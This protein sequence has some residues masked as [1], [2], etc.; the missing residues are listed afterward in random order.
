MIFSISTTFFFLE[1]KRNEKLDITDTLSPRGMPGCDLSLFLFQRD[2]EAGRE[3]LPPFAP[4]PC[5][6]W[7]KGEKPRALLSLP[8]QEQPL[9]AAYP[10]FSSRKKSQI[11][12]N[13]QLEEQLALSPTGGAG[14]GAGRRGEAGED[15]SFAGSSPKYQEF[16]AASLTY[17]GWIPRGAVGKVLS[18]F[19]AV[20]CIFGSQKSGIS[21]WLQA[22]QDR[23]KKKAPGSRESVEVSCGSPC[24]GTSP[25]GRS[26][27]DTK[28]W[29]SRGN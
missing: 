27:R 17:Q 3:K 5:G 21:H 6:R 12:Q 19:I 16:P 4:S 22:K 13:S 10:R 28:P 14:N 23:G 20:R 9:A 11:L 26:Q 1:G 15:L 25:T 2:L 8:S 7:G 24:P 29:N 18:E